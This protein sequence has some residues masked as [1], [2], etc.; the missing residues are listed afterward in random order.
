MDLFTLKSSNFTEN[1]ADWQGGVGYLENIEKILI[2]DSKFLKNQ[3]KPQNNSQGGSFSIINSEFLALKSTEIIDSYAQLYGGGL[4][5]YKVYSLDLK[6]MK[7]INNK[8]QFDE[9][10]D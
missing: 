3:V 2:E 5:L 10:I 8:V 1:Q 4:Y 7:F 9:K 6:Y